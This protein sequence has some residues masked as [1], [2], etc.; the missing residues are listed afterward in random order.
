MNKAHILVVYNR[1]IESLCDVDRDEVV[2]QVRR[3]HNTG[4]QVCEVIYNVLKSYEISLEDEDIELALEY[5][6]F[7]GEEI[8]HDMTIQFNASVEYINSVSLPYGPFLTVDSGW[9]FKFENISTF[10][11][12]LSWRRR[13]L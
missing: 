11:Y 2:R 9:I 3:L 6:F 4:R 1:W 12:R 7:N 5:Y 13:G 10:D 8:L